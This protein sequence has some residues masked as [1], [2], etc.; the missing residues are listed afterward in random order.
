MQQQNAEAFP[1]D[2]DVQ[3]R[4]LQPA[5][6]DLKTRNAAAKNYFVQD[7]EVYN[8]GKIEPLAVTA[9]NVRRVWNGSSFSK[10]YDGTKD[11]KIGGL[12]MG[13]L[14]TDGTSNAADFKKKLKLMLDLST[15]GSVEL[16][17]TM[18]GEDKADAAALRPHYD[19]KIG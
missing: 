1:I 12:T 14:K 8:K 15:G 19:D 7:G 18:Y 13:E 9:G 17:Y 6:S 16:D 11:A 5:F 2:R 4:N 3:Y 10:T